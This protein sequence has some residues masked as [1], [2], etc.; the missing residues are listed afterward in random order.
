MVSVSPDEWKRL[1]ETVSFGDILEG[2]VSVHAPFGF[3]LRLDRYPE[4]TAVVLISEYRPNGE[5]CVDQ[6]EFPPVGTR[7]RGAVRDL[8]DPTREIRLSVQPEHTRRD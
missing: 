6:A 8:V 1:R 4:A 2:A 3:F 7:V 5:P